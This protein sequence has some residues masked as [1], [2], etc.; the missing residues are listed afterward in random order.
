M[1]AG[2]ASSIMAA[3][4]LAEH[5]DLWAG[6]IVITL[7]GDEETMGDLG[8]KWLLE[9]VEG[10]VGD[11]MICGDVGS[12][13]VVRFGEKGFVWVEV[14]AEGVAAHG[15]H[16][17]KGVNAINRLRAAL[18]AVQ[19]LEDI[20]VA[21]PDDVGGAVD[22]A[23]GVSESLSGEGETHT[24]RHVTVNIGTFNAGV[25]PN[26]IPSHAKAQIDIRIPLGVS[27]SL[28]LDR[29]AQS[30]DPMEGVT[31]RAIRKFEPNYTPPGHEFVKSALSVCSEVM[32]SPAVANMRVGASDSRLYRAAGIPTVVV[33]CT[34]YN[35]GNA[36]EYVM[37]DELVAVAQIHT[38]MAYDFL[39]Q[40]TD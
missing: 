31:W 2:I 23:M 40:P 25:S 17:H 13:R 9:N 3:K 12:P 34:P 35:M 20:E 21:T 29:L 27:T 15:A 39:K 36:D 19:T 7:A 37:T 33:G 18:D 10:A 1:K 38:L 8:T 16:V 32:Q 28:L 26:L 30:L 22:A 24:L 4:V 6:E 11:V 5:R 14:E